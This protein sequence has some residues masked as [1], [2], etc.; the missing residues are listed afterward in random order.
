MGYL[1]NLNYQNRNNQLIRIY[2]I[3]S[4]RLHTDETAVSKISYSVNLR[5]DKKFQHLKKKLGLS[6][7]K[8]WLMRSTYASDLYIQRDLTFNDRDLEI[9]V[10]IIMCI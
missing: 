8:G 6:I 3:L 4:I 2:E 5:F 10:V 7:F 9:D 1:G